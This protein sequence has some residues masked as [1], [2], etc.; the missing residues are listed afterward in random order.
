MRPK[1]QSEDGANRGEPGWKLDRRR[2][3]GNDVDT[4][5]HSIL[6][7]RDR[8][9]IDSNERRKG[10]C[11]VARRCSEAGRGRTGTGIGV[12]NLGTAE[13]VQ[14]QPPNARKDGKEVADVPGGERIGIYGGDGGWLGM[15]G[16][17]RHKTML[18]RD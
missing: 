9:Q 15:R 10:R 18:R 1:V 4:D 14:I 12:G 5:S 6:P 11:G 3:H 17:Y 2:R 16:K 7:T 8:R 13:Y